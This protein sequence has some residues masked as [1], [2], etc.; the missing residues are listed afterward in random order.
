MSTAPPITILFFGDIVGKPGRRVLRRYLAKLDSK[1]DLIVANVGKCRGWI[2]RNR[3][4]T[5]RP[6]NR[7]CANFQRRQPYIRSKGNL[8]FIDREPNVLRPANS[9]PAGTA[10][11]GHCV[12]ELN[13]GIDVGF[14]NILG[15]IF[16]EP[17]ASP[18]LVA[19]EIVAKLAEECK[20]IF[21]DMHAEAT[22]EKVMLGWYLDGRVSS[23]GHAYSRTNGGRQDFVPQG[24][25]YITDVGCCGPAGR[26]I[27]MNRDDV[28]R[29][30][31]QQLPQRLSIAPGP[32]CVCGVKVVIDSQTG[33]AILIERIMRRESEEEANEEQS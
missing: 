5:Q 33:R 2:R 7:R 27:G 17:L 12:V 25:A 26:I 24:T 14:L 11:R 22:A 10:G 29:R 21:V 19:D 30:M 15:R 20:I 6:E 1:P 13:S 16:M 3:N 28:A 31:I 8:G 32:A 4:H 23:R 18:Y 9:I